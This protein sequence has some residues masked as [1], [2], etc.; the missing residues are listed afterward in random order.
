MF[1]RVSVATHHA[2]PIRNGIKE[3]GSF[4]FL[5]LFF[6][7]LFFFC[8]LLLNDFCYFLERRQQDNQEKDEIIPRDCFKNST[9]EGN[10][11]QERWYKVS[12]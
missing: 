12:A 3:I 9:V 7:V 2:V 8:F 5:C 6:F 10:E 11:N 1:F 4:F